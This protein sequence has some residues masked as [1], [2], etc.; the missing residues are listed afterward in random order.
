LKTN[1]FI[2][3]AA[4]CCIIT[5]VFCQKTDSVF[6]H[7]IEPVSVTGN[8]TEFYKE[9]KFILC[10]DSLSL[11]RNQNQ[12]IGE[13]LH[14]ESAVIIR[15]YGGSGSLS[16]LSFRGTGS[17]HSL[18]CWNG[19]PLN[20]L[21]TGDMD[22]SVINTDMADQIEIVKGTPGAQYGSGTFGG[23]I[24]INTIPDWNNRFYVKL[25]TE[26]G[27]F[28]YNMVNSPLKPDL[29]QLD[30]R[31][32]SFKLKIGDS[33][34]QS[35]T[36]FMH[37]KALN[38]YPNID[39]SMFN[40][41]L[42]IQMHNRFNKNAFIQNFNYKITKN[43]LL[44]VNFWLE[45]KYY[46]IP[47]GA[48]QGDSSLKVLMKWSKRNEKSII[49]VKTGYLYDYL[50]YINRSL[51]SKIGS[52]R[53][54]NDFN[55]RKYLTSTFTIEGGLSVSNFLAKNN[56]Y[57]SNSIYENLFNFYI[58]SK[59]VLKTLAINVLARKDIS[60]QY[61]TQPQFSIG[62]SKKA[63]SVLVLK[64]SLGNKFRLPTFN[65][66]YWPGWGNQDIKPENGWS[67]D[68]G[69]EILY[70][71]KGVSNKAGI[72]CYS[73][74]VN[75]W[76]QSVQYLAPGLQ[77]HNFLQVW[78]RGIEC[79]YELNVPY[80]Q[81]YLKFSSMYN[82]TPTTS[83]KTYS[84]DK[85]NLGKQVMLIPLHSFHGGI[86]AKYKATQIDFNLNTRSKSYTNFSSQGNA[87]EGYSIAS[88]NLGQN[89]AFKKHIFRID[90]KIN[91]IGNVQYQLIPA[92]QMPGRALYISISY[93][94]N[95]NNQ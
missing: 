95:K 29:G 6:V 72:V 70:T 78:A 56:N 24:D 77:A 59:Y 63:G 37:Q 91:N 52:H 93:I 4:F 40:S 39:K 30:S 66:R 25:N 62:F 51:N 74:I 55:I 19:F 9:D 12:N 45:G 23:V 80:S 11:L 54:L 69:S 44:E 31:K 5:H 34:F 21:S 13:L 64:G 3:I 87:L 14:Q 8:R 22:L 43:Q 68:G 49:S 46:E 88:I 26:V 86:S 61:Q 47:D 76:I 33:V 67:I 36:A 85:L 35:G 27:F 89:I 94:F 10:F 73:T 82:F 38:E 20:A 57:A 81:G 71:I 1:R 50:N 48:V 16:T 53:L 92:Y 18:V 58:G 28:D 79:L 84:S 65:E 75:D 32:F 83:T 7:K 60:S 17:N 41:P 42:T 90:G 15:Q 2:A